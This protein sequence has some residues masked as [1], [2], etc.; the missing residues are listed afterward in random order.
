[1]QMG[2][3]WEEEQE[4]MPVPILS[5]SQIAWHLKDLVETDYHL[6]DVWVQGEVSNYSQSSAGHCYFVLKDATAQL[7]CVLFRGNRTLHMPTLH[8]GMAVVVHGRISFYET[9]G[10]VQLYVNDMADTGIGALHL[11]FERLKCRLQ[12][13]GLFDEARKRPLPAAPHVIGIVTSPTGAALRDMLKV[14]RSRYPLAEVILAPTLV[15]GDEAAEQI[16]QAIDLLA[17]HGMADV[18]IL[19]RGGGSL[20]DLWAF[21][22]EIVARAI[23]RSHIPIITGI[24]HEIDFTI[25]DFAADYRASTPT[26]A[27]T[28]AVP[29]WREVAQ[30]VLEAQGMLVALMTD[31]LEQRRDAV[32]VIW[33]ELPRLSPAQWCATMRQRLID[34]TRPLDDG[35]AHILKLKREQL[36]GAM[37]QLDTLSP[38]LTLERGYSI[39]RRLPDGPV[40]TSVATVGV[41][42]TLDIHVRD[43]HI[44]CAVA[45]A[46]CKEE[47]QCTKLN[48]LQ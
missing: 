44:T 6:Q 25:A 37:R 45:Q 26:A 14:L 31:Y 46:T 1:M 18:I 30:A 41:G 33:A 7:K 21:N 12:A 9:S 40:V 39:V 17:A 27:A 48:R 35:A 8:N 16:S 2:T 42:D 3:T 19:A 11:A 4:A 34:L 28:A 36:Q 5:V 43:G 22:E 20:E 38:L 23:V 29:D 32:A 24:G 13:E 10:A 47:V 15:Q